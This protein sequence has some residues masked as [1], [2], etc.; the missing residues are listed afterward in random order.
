MKHIQF[1]IHSRKAKHQQTQLDVISSYSHL[2]SCCRWTD[3]HSKRMNLDIRACHH[4]PP[5]LQD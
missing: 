3:R 2:G 5:L 1:L 4:V